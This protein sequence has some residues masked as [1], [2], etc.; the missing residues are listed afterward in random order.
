MDL[1]RVFDTINYD[2]LI[3]KLYACGFEKNALD[4]VYSQLKN[5]KQGV[6]TNAT[7]RI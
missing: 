6:K 7:F 3:T 4:L 1:F 5:R 2:L